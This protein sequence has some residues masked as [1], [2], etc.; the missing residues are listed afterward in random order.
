MKALI[1]GVILCAA[2]VLTGCAPTMTETSDQ[3]AQR[4]NQQSELQ[5][6]MLAEDIDIV[7]LLDR[8]SSLTKWHSY[9]GN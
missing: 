1:I 3:H 4:I 7:L 8:S 5:M 9:I 6:R 2:A